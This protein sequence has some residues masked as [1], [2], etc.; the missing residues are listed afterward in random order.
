MTPY[1]FAGL[2]ME[3]IYKYLGSPT[4]YTKVNLIKEAVCNEFNLEM[5]EIMG[6]S[7][8]RR[9][10]EPR[11]VVYYLVRKELGLTYKYTG[12]LVANQDHATVIYS[13]RRISDLMFTDLD[14]AEKVLRANR[15]YYNLL[16]Q[17]NNKK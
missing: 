9:I 4:T 12:F 2:E 8:L 13:E 1:I 10:V 3:T 14:F 5:N 6:R 16:K 15:R 7:R 17:F 11:Q